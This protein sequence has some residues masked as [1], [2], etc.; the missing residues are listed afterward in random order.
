MYVGGEAQ[1]CN[2]W[3]NITHTTELIINTTINKTCLQCLANGTDLSTRWDILGIMIDR[4]VNNGGPTEG[5]EVVN[6]T[7]VIL[8]PMAVITEGKTNTPL[9]VQC[10]VNSMLLEA[11]I[12][13][14]GNLNTMIK[15]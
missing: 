11:K 3:I 2:E 4:L 6:G 13:S 8:N 5:F 9:V 15:T 7:L 14:S 10:L 1:D 12:F